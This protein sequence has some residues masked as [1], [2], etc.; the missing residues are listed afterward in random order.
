MV[1]EPFT[2]TEQIIWALE[3][4]D[5]EPSQDVVAALPHL[6]QTAEL[7]SARHADDPEL[8]AAGLVHDLASAL[9]SGI[10]DH[11]QAGAALVRHVLG[12]RVADLVAGHT[13]AKRYLVT[14]EPHYATSL[15]ANSALTLEAQGGGMTGEDSDSFRS[16]PDSSSMVVLRRA[17]D[18]AKVPDRVARPPS[19]WRDL[20]DRVASRQRR[21]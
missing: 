16:R 2:S 19:E 5:G 14:V 6:L 11:A 18:A 21:S 4:L 8:I 20:L 1:E 17:D 10:A 13:E 12:D 3:S 15:S 7:L 9:E